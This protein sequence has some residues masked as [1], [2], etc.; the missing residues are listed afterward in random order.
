MSGI[1][2]STTPLF[3]T[4]TRYQETSTAPDYN[5]Q[6]PESSIIQQEHLLEPPRIV[7]FGVR[8][9]LETGQYGQSSHTASASLSVSR[10]EL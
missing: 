2:E 3:L 5:L 6:I 4:R 8:R 9:L 10:H 7:F 1:D